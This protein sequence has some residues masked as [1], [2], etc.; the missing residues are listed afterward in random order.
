MPCS[1]YYLWLSAN[2]GTSLSDRDFTLD[3]MELMLY[4]TQHHSSRDLWLEK[5]IPS[6]TPDLLSQ[7][8]WGGC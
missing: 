2:R 3:E 4:Y 6:P 5:E 8:V 7:E 1:I